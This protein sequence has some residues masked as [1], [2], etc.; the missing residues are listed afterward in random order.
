VSPAVDPAVD[1]ALRAAF[2]LLFGAAAAHKLRD[3]GRFRAALADYR[4]LPAPLVGPAAIGLGVIE[5]VLAATLVVPGTRAQGLAGAAALLAVY[6]AAVAVNLGRGR[7]ALDCGCLGI[8]GRES[9]SWWLVGRNAMMAGAALAAL[10]PIAERPLVWVDAVTV[11]GAVALGAFTWL[12]FDGLLANRSG[13][14]R[15]RGAA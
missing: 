7:R 6:A 15:I 5:T 11:A 14:A 9:I 2:A 8:G 1:V 12:A 10:R 13:V 3:P 4:L